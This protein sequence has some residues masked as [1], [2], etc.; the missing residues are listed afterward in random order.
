MK[1]WIRMPLEL[2]Q[3]QGMRKSTA[4]VLGAIIDK[5]TDKKGYHPKEIDRAELSQDTGYSVRAIGD[6][7]RELQTLQLIHAER[8]GRGS[9]YT[10]TGAVEILPPKKSGGGSAKAERI[11]REEAERIRLEQEEAEYLSLSNRFKEDEP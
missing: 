5:C 4:I 10:L 11:Q 3:R 2:L 8:T 9:V 7:L 1:A 6:A